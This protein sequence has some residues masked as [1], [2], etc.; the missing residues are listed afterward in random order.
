MSADN[1]LL[2][3]SENTKKEFLKRRSKKFEPKELDWKKI[4]RKI[5]CWNAKSRDTQKLLEKNSKSKLERNFKLDSFKKK[6]KTNNSIMN[7]KEL[8][9]QYLQYYK[10]NEGKIL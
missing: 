9:A 7:T 8:L 6:Q 3:N 5:D 2:L 4:E 1:I 10:T